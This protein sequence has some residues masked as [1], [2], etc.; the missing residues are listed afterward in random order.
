LLFR[1]LIINKDNGDIVYIFSKRFLNIHEVSK[2]D[3]NLK[4]EIDDI[5]RNLLN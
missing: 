1:N 4:E 3:D 2:H 5:K